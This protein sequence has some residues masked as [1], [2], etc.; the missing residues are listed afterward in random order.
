MSTN[1]FTEISEQLAEMKA[2]LYEVKASQHDVAKI[3]QTSNE[4][5][6]SPKEAVKLFTPQISLVTIHVWAEAGK[7]KKHRL[8]GRV[9]Y[10]ASEIIESLQHLRKYQ[11]AS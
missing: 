9:Y 10:K 6:L 5:L 7:L 1:P 3:L 2:T 11:R 8:G 4:R